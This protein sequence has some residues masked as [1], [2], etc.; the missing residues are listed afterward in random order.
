MDGTYGN[1]LPASRAMPPTVPAASSGADR[2]KVNVSR[3][4]TQKWANFKPANYGDG[5]GDDDEDEWDEPD[6]P[7]P[8]RPMGPRQ[9]TAALPSSS[10]SSLLPSQAPRNPTASTQSLTSSLGSLPSQSQ[11][12]LVS[13]RAPATSSPFVRPA[14]IYKRLEEEKRQPPESA[15]PNLGTVAAEGDRAQGEPN[16]YALS[17]PAPREGA[18]LGDAADVN[19]RGAGHGLST[20]HERRSDYGLEGLLDSYGAEETNTRPSPAPPLSPSAKTN[21]AAFNTKPVQE[22]AASPTEAGVELRRF[23]SSPQLPLVTRL[24]GFG[25]DLFSHNSFF[26]EPKQEPVNQTSAPAGPFAPPARVAPATENQLQAKSPALA[27]DLSQPSA[28]ARPQDGSIAA[29]PS[30]PAQQQP[31]ANHAREPASNTST[32]TSMQG[33]VVVRPSLPG[34]W[35]SETPVTPGETLL[36]AQLIPV[37]PAA[38]AAAA[39]APAPAPALANQRDAGTAGVPDGTQQS[40]QPGPDHSKETSSVRQEATPSPPKPLAPSRTSSPASSATSQMSRSQASQQHDALPEVGT[41][42]GAAIPAALNTSTHNRN[43]TPTAPLNPRR[44]A[45]DVSTAV[46]PVMSPPSNEMESILETD[47]HSPLKDSDMLSEEIIKSLSP[48][49]SSES[50][51]NIEGATTDAYQ[52]VANQPPDS[53]VRESSYLGD[54]YDDYW[55][56]SEE[57]AEEVA[58]TGAAEVPEQAQQ[59]PSAPASPTEAL[60]TAPISTT[61]QA[62]APLQVTPAPAK[63]SAASESQQ[64]ASPALGDSRRRF[65]WE[66]GFSD[67]QPVV[68]Q[69]TA[70]PPAVEP[71]SLDFTSAATPAIPNTDGAVSDGK[72]PEGVNA[73]SVSQASTAV[74]R[75]ANTPSE[76]SSPVSVVSEKHGNRASPAPEAQ[77]KLSL[78]DSLF[79]ASPAPALTDDQLIPRAM[80]PRASSPNLPVNILS[81]RQILEMGPPTERI[82]HFDETRM[83][84]ASI[85]TGLDEW[86]AIMSSKHPEH[87]SPG[88]GAS[89]EALQSPGAQVTHYQ[90]AGH[91]GGGGLPA[92]IPMPPPQNHGTGFS[93]LHGGSNKSRELLM[94]AGKAGKGLFSKGR[95][96]LRGTG[97]KVFSNP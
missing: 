79:G 17:D 51:G 20:V 28:G 72:A 82:K 48:V 22:A 2:Y 29:P 88:F 64:A 6:P 84:F 65:S 24:S 15:R 57:K 47:A 94:A 16:R 36:P 19:A 43:I 23:S 61:S 69:L 60:T 70:T 50:F 31:A 52:A 46:L 67:P 53:P 76:P 85:D 32:G 39:P 77:Q 18:G 42:P 1:Y 12:S 38:A 55:A 86:L 41:G 90:H 87:N 81:F 30:L 13:P 54:V 35:V 8:A 91:M 74:P 56:A 97:D 44:D 45:P 33:K 11:Q 37:E 58:T 25:E 96:K 21:I 68:T 63:E 80:V 71:K 93:H 92:N 3:Q 73:F 89:R 49:Q 40:S 66:A 4:K 34:G 9:P 83:Q 78:A 27:D 10:A 14:D 62:P 75:S 5:W 59:P 95:N 7:P 26:A